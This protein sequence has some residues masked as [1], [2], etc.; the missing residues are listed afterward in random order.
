MSERVTVPATP[1]TADVLPL[2]MPL[3]EP[4]E[5][6]PSTVARLELRCSSC[7]YGAIAIAVPD[8]CPMCSSSDWDFADWRP[9]SSA[10]RVFPHR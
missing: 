10:D 9:F 7:G 1:P 5:P 4:L 6:A 2:P 8:R 3:G